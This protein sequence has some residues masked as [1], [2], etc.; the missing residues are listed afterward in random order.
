MTVSLYIFL[1][2]LQFYMST[3]LAV[4]GLSIVP[5]V[6]LL[7]IA[8]GRYVRK[9]TQSVQVCFSLMVVFWFVFVNFTFSSFF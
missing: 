1:F 3:K 5:P 2:F 4:V 9:I 8:Y 6:A 7:A